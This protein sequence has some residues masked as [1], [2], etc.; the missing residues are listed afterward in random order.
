MQQMLFI[1]LAGEPGQS[2]HQ[3]DAFALTHDGSL[4]TAGVTLD[5][6]TVKSGCL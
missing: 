5:N 2:W 1:K 4:N 6:A 3:D